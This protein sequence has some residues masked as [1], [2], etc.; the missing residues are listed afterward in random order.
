VQ[1][2]MWIRI[3][4][5]AIQAIALASTVRSILQTR[6]AVRQSAASLE[7]T[8]ESV[9]RLE[10]ATAA[11]EELNRQRMALMQGLRATR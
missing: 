1:I 9:K 11:M 3:A 5:L 4:F 8:K 10:A 2:V 7:S 6:Q